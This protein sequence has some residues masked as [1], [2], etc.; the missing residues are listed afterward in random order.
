MNAAK[1]ALQMSSSSTW[2][3]DDKV[4]TLVPKFKIKDGMREP[5]VALLPKFVELVKANEEESCVHYGF[6]GPTEDGFAICREGYISAEAVLKHLDN[7]GD[8]LNEALQYADIV[9]LMIQGP[10]EE[11]KKLEEPLAHFGPTHYPLV[12]GS[13]RSKA[14][15]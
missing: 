10:A 3:E 8:V 15:P 6:V 7:V 12:E 2:Y 9:E 4:I 5:Y 13:F 11:L 1:T 14:Q